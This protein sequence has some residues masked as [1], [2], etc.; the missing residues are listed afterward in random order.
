M[1]DQH[2]DE[3]V[4][5][6]CSLNPLIGEKTVSGRL[7]HQG[8]YVQRQRIRDALRRI[9]P[10]GVKSRA[11]G[12]LHRRQY[13]VPAPNDLWHL[14]GYHKLIRWS[15][16]IYGGIDGFS[17]VIMYLNVATNNRS[18]TVLSSFLSAVREYGQI[19]VVR[20][21]VWHSTC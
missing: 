20:M 16:V 2:L 18:D 19:V 9:D 7:K 4:R 21:L 11:K 1:S 5:Q 17:R 6:I 10:T 13:S 14:D 8:I 15:L 12:V 3:C